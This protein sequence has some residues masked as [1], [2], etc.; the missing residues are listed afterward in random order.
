MHPPV[1]ISIKASSSE[2]VQLQAFL[3]CTR[4][5]CLL[6]ISCVGDTA[7]IRSQAV[8]PALTHCCCH[9]GGEFSDNGLDQLLIEGEA[10]SAMKKMLQQTRDLDMQEGAVKLL[11]RLCS[12][13]D[14]RTEV[15][16]GLP[17][18]MT[19]PCL[20]CLQ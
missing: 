11:V 15:A 18:C 7:D 8:H 17:P 14:S 5:R 13:A 12:T 9:A 19:Q 1:A 6:Q 10:I 16:A 4:H 3:C 20:Y 2:L